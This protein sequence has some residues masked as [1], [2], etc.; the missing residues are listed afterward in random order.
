MARSILRAVPIAHG[1]LGACIDFGIVIRASQIAVLGSLNMDLVQRVPRMPHPGE[2]LPA[3]DFHT[4]VGGKGANQ[5]CA[6]AKLGASVEM[7]GMVGDDLF[8][9]R[10]RQALRDLGVDIT[11]I[12]TSCN[13]SGTAII[14]VLPNGENAI[15]ISAGA[16]ADV[17]PEFALKAINRLKAGD[18]LL[19]QLEIPLEA[20][21][22]ALRTAQ[23]RG[24]LT[25]LDPAPARDLPDDLLR[26]AALLTPNQTEAALLVGNT[27]SPTT[28][29]EARMT[30]AA[31]LRRGPQTVILKMGALGCLVADQTSAVELP[32]FPVE[33]I[34]TTAAGDAFN[35]ALAVRLAEGSSLIEA[36]RFANAAAALSVTKAGAVSSMP[37]RFEVDRFLALQTAKT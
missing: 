5:A 30:A 23:E 8:A 17:T 1:D 27:G 10:L 32:G 21:Q 24:I 22:V 2:T 33:A 36:A 16:N 26:T 9:L 18:L 37:S 13:P 29:P 7:S 25:I 14:L 3:I 34:D 35:G 6:A 31:L 12:G 15:V 28:P 11:G 19:C 4:Y 20:V